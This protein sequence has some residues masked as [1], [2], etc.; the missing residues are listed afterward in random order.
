M[1]PPHSALPCGGE[2]HLADVIR[3]ALFRA[4]PP[5]RILFHG[6][7]ENTWL[8]WLAGPFREILT[9]HIH[10]CH[11]AASQLCI[12]ELIAADHALA[13]RLPPAASKASTLAAGPLLDAHHG[14]SALQGFHR[15]VSAA[16]RGN[17]P[18]HF[19]TLIAA[20]AAWFYLPPHAPLLACAYVEWPG[21]QPGNI[22]LFTSMYPASNILPPAASPD[23][24]PALRTLAR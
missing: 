20:R 16:R 9:P 23:S 14:A 13:S 8:A 17:T 21:R 15:L 5:S 7:Q 19:S 1:P 3:L 12:E 22:P 4:N 18:G 11:H 24:K 10:L 2:V 6:R